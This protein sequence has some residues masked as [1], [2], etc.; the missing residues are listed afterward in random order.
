MGRR[1]RP[2]EHR[3]VPR[4]LA[5]R[6]DGMDT[7]DGIA[8]SGVKPHAFGCITVPFLLL[9]LV[10]LLWGARAQWTKGALLRGGETVPGTV[11][12]LRHVPGN[13][14]VT[15]GTRHS[16]H[17]GRCAVVDFTTRTGERRTAVSS[18]NRYPAPWTPGETVNVVYDPAAPGRA[19]L[20]SELTGWPL[21]FGIWVGVSLLPLAIAAAPGVLALRDRRR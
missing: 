10:P 5:A 7:S 18:V 6:E 20:R 14:S 21:W 2:C 9:A 1:R 16:K 3:P 13:P 12:E 11:T 19:D 8:G 15:R 17:A 4:L